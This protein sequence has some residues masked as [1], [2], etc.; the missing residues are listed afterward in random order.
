ME[1]FFSWFAVGVYLVCVSWMGWGYGYW[2]ARAK[3]AEAI[4]DANHWNDEFRK[5]RCK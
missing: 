4:L 3:W 2:R 5:N 1:L